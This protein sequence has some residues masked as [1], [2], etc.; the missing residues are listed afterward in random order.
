[1]TKPT[2]GTDRR[3]FLQ[4]LMFAGAAVGASSVL[5][6]SPAKAQ[7]PA[8]EKARAPGRLHGLFPIA[9]T[10]VDANDKIDMDAL[11]GQVK[12]CQRGGVPGIA[13][14]QIASG[15]T[16]LSES[17]RMAGAEAM[18][19]AGKGGKTAVAIGLQSPDWAAVQRYAKH[20]EEHGAGAVLCI[21]PSEITDDAGLLTYYQRVGGLTSKPLIVQAV[22]NFSIDLLVKIYETVPTAR[23]VKDESGEPLDRAQEIIRRTNGDMGVW[24]GRG[25]ATMVTEMERGFTG[26][27]PYVSLADVYQSAYELW[28]AGKKP[29][30]FQRFGAIQACNT[31]FSQSTPEALIARGVFKPG[32]RTRVAGQAAGANTRRMPAGTPD[33]IKRILDTYMKPYLRA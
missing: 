8:A 24:S 2:T 10:P 15:W 23:Y 29:E 16:V 3:A 11:A 28:H 33:E 13:W 31:L 5:T 18:L 9:F 12:F 1:M 21:P 30:A 27:C 26:H 17:E 22:G 4:S 6:T 20:A 25:V 14:P 19:D 7:V 32:T